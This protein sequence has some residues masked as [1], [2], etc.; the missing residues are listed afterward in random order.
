MRLVRFLA[1]FHASAVFP[2]S[3]RSRRGC[4]NLAIK[5]NLAMEAMEENL[6]MEVA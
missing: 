4:E 6:A 5:E 3:E 2:A 1:P